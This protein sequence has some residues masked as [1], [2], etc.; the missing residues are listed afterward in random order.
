VTAGVGAGVGLAVGP[1]VGVGDGA[2]VGAGV[3]PIGDTPA[4]APSDEP[5]AEFQFTL[6]S[7][8]PPQLI[9]TAGRNTAAADRRR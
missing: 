5:F 1:G 6:L 9:S 4:L 8:P 3:V 2:G 7:V